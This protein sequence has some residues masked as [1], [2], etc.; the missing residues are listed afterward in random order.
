MIQSLIKLMDSMDS[1]VGEL[2][3]AENTACEAI[4]LSEECRQV[5]AHILTR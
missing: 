2:V 3:I 4:E 1:N 5:V